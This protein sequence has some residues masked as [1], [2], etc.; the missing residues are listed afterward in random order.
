[1]VVPLVIAVA[2]RR[3]FALLKVVG[4]V[5]DADR[6]KHGGKRTSAQ[7]Q[8]GKPHPFTEPPLNGAGALPNGASG[9][10]VRLT[11]NG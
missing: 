1:M 11:L 2:H 10:Y 9:R 5:G 3:M 8:G 7:Q 6:E 4:Y